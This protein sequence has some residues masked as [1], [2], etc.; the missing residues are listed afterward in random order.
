MR[1]MNQ[2]AGLSRRTNIVVGLIVLTAL[3]VVTVLVCKYFLP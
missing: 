3:Y 2:E 1:T